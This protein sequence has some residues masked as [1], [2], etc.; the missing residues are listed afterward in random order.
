[1][2][3]CAEGIVLA[4]E[5]YDKPDP[6]NLGAGFE[7]SIKDLADLIV[8]RTGF[9]GRIAWDTSKP[10]GQPRR[11]LNV[12]RAEREFGFHAR[13]GFEE[14]LEKTIEWY[15]TVRGKQTHADD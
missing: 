14:G 6:V 3:D 13:T 12:G 1:V 2:E 11:C 4:T 9:E 5:K 7:I 8:E 15:R 10:G